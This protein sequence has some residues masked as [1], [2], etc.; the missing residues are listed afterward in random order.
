MTH[1][2]TAWQRFAERA[3][4]WRTR[5]NS[6]FLI[7]KIDEQTPLMGFDVS[8]LRKGVRVKELSAVDEVRSGG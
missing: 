6:T 8:N 2:D 4:V 7:W 3:S 1:G 5:C